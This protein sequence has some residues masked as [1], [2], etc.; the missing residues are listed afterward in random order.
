MGFCNVKSILNK[1]SII[2]DFLSEFSLDIFGVAETWLLPIIPDSF[3]SKDHYNIARSD[4]PDETRKN[5]VCV[6]VKKT[7]S[8]I[9]L[10]INNCKHVCAIHLIN[11]NLLVVIVCRSPSYSHSEN[12]N[13][14][15]FLTNFCT[16]KE[17]L[18]LGDFNLPL[19]QCI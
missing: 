3:A 10:E 1:I 6:Y 4:S 9:S 5:G 16:N 11:F 12:S 7:L 14:F 8:Y 2:D 19:I 15:E 18:I 17:V 13:L